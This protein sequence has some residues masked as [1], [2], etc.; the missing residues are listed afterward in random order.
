[1][2]TD[3]A[4]RLWDMATQIVHQ[5]LTERARAQIQAD[6]PE[7]E[8]FLPMFNQPG[9]D[10]LARLRSFLNDKKHPSNED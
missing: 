2:K 10:L 6:M 8:T 3:R 5:P 7:Y 9:L 1:M 4:Y